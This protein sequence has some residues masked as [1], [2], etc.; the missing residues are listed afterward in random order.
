MYSIMKQRAKIN[1]S[2]KFIN[3]FSLSTLSL[4]I[5]DDFAQVFSMWHLLMTTHICTTA[6]QMHSSECMKYTLNVTENNL[7]APKAVKL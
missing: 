1:V 3:G 2:Q 6:L 4:E 5:G 7:A